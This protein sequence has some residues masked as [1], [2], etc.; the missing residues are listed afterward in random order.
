MAKELLKNLIVLKL[1]ILDEIFDAIPVV[2][3]SSVKKCY[4]ELVNVVNEATGDYI[5][6]T[7]SN[8]ENKDK[9]KLKNIDIE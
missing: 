8:K 5:K 4:K 7:K 3:D 2:S 9:N 6:E 1:K